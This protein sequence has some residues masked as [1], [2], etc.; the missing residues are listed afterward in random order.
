MKYLLCE[1]TT[2]DNIIVI[3]KNVTEDD[4]KSICGWS[5]K[6]VGKDIVLI[7]YKNVK[8]ESKNYGNDIE[9]KIE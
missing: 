3:Q 5:D 4:V 6:Y 9:V 1:I 2:D 7:P 8:V